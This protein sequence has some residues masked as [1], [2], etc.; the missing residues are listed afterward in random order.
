M[1]DWSLTRTFSFQGQIIRYD[2]RGNGPPVVLVH[3]TPWSSVAKE[4]K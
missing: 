2:V 4:T 3:G 1:G